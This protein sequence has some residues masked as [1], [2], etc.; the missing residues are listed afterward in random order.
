MGPV[1]FWNQQLVPYLQVPLSPNGSSGL[2]EPAAGLSSSKSASWPSSWG[3]W[4]LYLSFLA[5]INPFSV[6]EDDKLAFLA[7][8]P[9]C[10][11]WTMGRLVGFS[12]R[13]CWPW[14]WMMGSLGMVMAFSS[15]NWSSTLVQLGAGTLGTFSKIEMAAMSKIL[16]SCAKRNKFQAWMARW[17]LHGIH[18]TNWILHT[19]KSEFCLPTWCWSFSMWSFTYM[20]VLAKWILNCNF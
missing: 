15:W 14:N 13:Y 9:P 2:L 7:T 8:L 18:I 11:N 3:S 5:W 1:A 4:P 17:P 12:L 16:A 20:H 19:S 6:V 10:M